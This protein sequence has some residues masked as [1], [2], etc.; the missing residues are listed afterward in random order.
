MGDGKGHNGRAMED[1]T[2]TGGCPK[3]NINALKDRLVTQAIL[4]DATLLKLC[5]RVAEAGN[6]DPS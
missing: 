2:A 6:G 5:S 3:V 4:F 1:I